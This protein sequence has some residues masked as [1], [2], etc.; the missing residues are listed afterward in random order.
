MMSCKFSQM[1]QDR[2]VGSDQS[3]IHKLKWSN[4]TSYNPH[5]LMQLLPHPLRGDTFPRQCVNSSEK[6]RDTSESERGQVN[7]NFERKEERVK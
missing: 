6:Q 4:V 1:M 5:L 7:T 3:F 2:V